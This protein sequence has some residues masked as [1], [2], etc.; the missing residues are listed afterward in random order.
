MTLDNSLD[1]IGLYRGFRGYR[2]LVILLPGI[3]HT[4]HFTSRDMGYCVQYVCLLLWDTCFKGSLPAY[5][6]ENADQEINVS[7]KTGFCTQTILVQT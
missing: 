1:S 6:K 4:I 5:L 7:E 3:W 2:I